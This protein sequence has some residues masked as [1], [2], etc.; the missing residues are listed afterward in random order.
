VV[1]TFVGY[2]LLKNMEKTFSLSLGFSTA[3]A[4]E[5]YYDMLE[6]T[7]VT[8]SV[9]WGGG[10]LFFL[11]LLVIPRLFIKPL[12]VLPRFGVNLL[13]AGLIGIVL[14]LLL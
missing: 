4:R 1:T 7:V 8:F 6:R 9:A 13:Y 2:Y 5:K 11:A 12:K 10:A 14:R 3:Q